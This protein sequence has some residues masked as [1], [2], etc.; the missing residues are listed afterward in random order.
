MNVILW[1]LFAFAGLSCIRLVLGPTLQDRLLSLNMISSI[2]IL[3]LCCIS[4]LYRKSFY[5]DAAIIYALLSFTE[6]IAF[7]RFYRIQE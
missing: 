5:I 3:V 1:I 6:I 7:L 2:L 4:L